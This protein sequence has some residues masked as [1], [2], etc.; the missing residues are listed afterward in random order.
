[1]SYKSAVSP[2]ISLI[3]TCRYASVNGYLNVAPSRRDDLESLGYIALYFLHGSLPWQGLKA[4]NRQEKYKLV[5]ER[6]KTIPMAELCHGLP[7]EFAAYMSYIREMGDQEKPNYKHLRELF[8]R[9]F[10]RNGF[11]RD[12]VFDWTLREFERLPNMD[13]HYLVPG[14]TMMKEKGST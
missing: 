6:K 13:Q 1:M 3:G 10:R 8:N 4:P 12:N 11:E 14:P 2:R 5:F 9:L 7:A